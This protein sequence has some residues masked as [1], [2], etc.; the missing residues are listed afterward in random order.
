MQQAER[1]AELVHLAVEAGFAEGRFVDDA[2][3]LQTIQSLLEQRI[4]ADDRA[5]LKGLEDLGRV[6][7]DH[8]QVAMRQQAVARL[9]HA[10]GMGC[11]VDQRQA[12]A[13]RQV[14]ERSRVTRR[15]KA[16]HR[17]QRN[18][19][20]RDQRLGVDRAQVE[21][22]RIDVGKHGCEACPVDRIGCCH[23]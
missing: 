19:V 6:K 12:M 17:Q 14:G 5:A 20:W 9:A 8:R 10:K 3:I 4:A 23:E 13:L 16:M 7:A 2:V 15:A 22:H 18:S 21:R 11:V 1:G